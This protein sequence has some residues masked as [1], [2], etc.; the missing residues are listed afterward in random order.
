MSRNLL[1]ADQV[2][3]RLGVKV[4]TVYAYVSRG[5]LS[6]TLAEDGRTSRFD[7]SEVEDLARR[8]RPRRGAGRPGVADV[9]LSTSLTSLAGDH[10]HYRGHDA[11]ELARATTFEAV[12]ELLWTGA[13]PNVAAWGARPDSVALARA[14]TE[15]L[16]V[17]SPVADRLAVVTAAVACA[18]PLRVDLQTQAVVGHGRSL[19]T[20]FAEVLPRQGRDPADRASRRRGLATTLW[21]RLSPLPATRAR[22]R[23]LDAALVLLADHELATSTLAARIAASTAADPYAVVLA[24]LG[25]ASGPRH[26]KA[27]LAVQQLLLDA[28]HLDAP[29]Q[30]VA[31]SLAGGG[32]I[33]GFGHPIY[34]DRDPRAECLLELLEPLLNRKT[35]A[36]VHGVREV[37]AATTS[38]M[39]NIDFA[40]G[41]L[42][43]AARMPVGLTEAIFVVARTSGWI[44]H[45]LEEYR[46]APLRFRARAIYTGPAPGAR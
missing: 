7:P 41:A 10:L 38:A 19:L 1:T 40:I 15:P 12:A 21:T 23:V 33:P 31:R 4:E 14:V 17:S 24:G 36:I 28:D 37:T 22:V 46:E 2:A 43:Y 18:E 45:A 35:G 27:G 20:I 8:G 6:R 26:G 44:A 3:A 25:A 13:L 29:E 9:V 30:A 32:R 42:A 5:V 16:P 39:V 11:T 34:V